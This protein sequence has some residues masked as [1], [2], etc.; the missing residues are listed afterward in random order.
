MLGH[1]YSGLKK[2]GEASYTYIW[3]VSVLWGA[4]TLLMAYARPTLVLGAGNRLPLGEVVNQHWIP[5]LLAQG[6]SLHDSLVSEWGS[7]PCS[8]E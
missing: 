4:S 5:T 1:T 3:G 7:T 8:Q 2:C 6:G